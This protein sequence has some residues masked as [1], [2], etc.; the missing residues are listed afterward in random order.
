MTYYTT[1]EKISSFEPGDQD[2]GFLLK[3]INKTNTNKGPLSL[4]DILDSAGL[5]NALWCMRACDLISKDARLF[6]VWCA[7]QVQHL[8]TDDRSIMALDIA[9]RFANGNATYDELFIAHDSAKHAAKNAL[10]VAIWAKTNSGTIASSWAVE[11]AAAKE[12]SKDAA[13]AAASSADK[14]PS[15]AAL[16]AAIHAA[17]TYESYWKAIDIQEA[18]FRRRFGGAK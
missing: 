13:Y 3:C 15:D 2:L 14:D 6:A 10:N 1:I 16:M 4:I 11:D 12:A 5:E 8:M 17:C 18:E 7:R 9:E